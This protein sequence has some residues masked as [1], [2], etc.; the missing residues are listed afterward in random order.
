MIKIA[1]I[2]HKKRGKDTLAKPLLGRGWTRIAF[3]DPLKNACKAIW[4]FTDEQLWGDLKEEP[5]S[6]W[7][8]T[9][10]QAMNFLGTWCMQD[11]IVSQFGKDKSHWVKI[12]QKQLDEI[13]LTKDN[14]IC[15]DL[16]FPHEWDMLKKE[17]FVFVKINPVGFEEEP[18][19]HESESYINTLESDYQI[20]NVWGDPDI[21]KT[22]FSKIINKIKKAK[23]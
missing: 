10:R 16:R 22:Q 8:I 7:E 21:M 15:T 2:A 13:Y 17:G 12:I 1:L 9:P 6:Y 11:G 19:L 3:A 18:I 14:I 5:D 23:N 20:D 4:G